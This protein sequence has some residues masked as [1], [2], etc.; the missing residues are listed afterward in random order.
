MQK[1]LKLLIKILVLSDMVPCIWVSIYH[2]IRSHIPQHRNIDTYS[3]E[4]FRSYLNYFEIR[5]VSH[6]IS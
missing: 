5:N 6:A 3:N 4:N 2:I 1:E